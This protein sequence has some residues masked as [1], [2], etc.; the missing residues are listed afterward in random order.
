MPELPFPT[1]AYGAHYIYL[2]SLSLIP[3]PSISLTP[4]GRPA[5]AATFSGSLGAGGA[6][7]QLLL[8]EEGAQVRELPCAGDAEHDDLDEG[9][10]HD[11]GI[12][13]LGLIAE[14][15]FA[16]LQQVSKKVRG[17]CGQFEGEGGKGGRTRWKSC[18]RLISHRRPLRSL[19][20][21]TRSPNL[22]VSSESSCEALPMARSR[23]SLT[24]PTLWPPSQ[25]VCPV[26]CEA[27]K[28]M[29]WSPESAE[30]KVTLPA[31][32][33]RL[34]TMRWSLSKTS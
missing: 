26:L 16:L 24:P 32:A 20:F 3:I 23:A 6:S 17:G 25:P 29:R 11:A 19:T 1:Y 18:S 10:A 5:L 22:P 31:C 7:R 33:P 21:W 2:F 12:G 8:D 13:R 28:Q 15:G 4:L 9:P 30:V 27:V 34:V 14:L